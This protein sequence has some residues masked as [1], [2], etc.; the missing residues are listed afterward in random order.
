MGLGY[1]VDILGALAW[2][3]EARQ[4]YWGDCDTHGF[5]ILNRARAYLP[6]L[7]S[8]LMDEKTILAYRA[9]WV[10]EPEQYGA[11]DLPLLTPEERSVYIALKGNLWARKVRLEQERIAWPYAAAALQTL[12]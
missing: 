3:R 10:E 1:S 8:V 4:Y 6:D 12:P 9:L 7:R 2:V 5:A 11:A